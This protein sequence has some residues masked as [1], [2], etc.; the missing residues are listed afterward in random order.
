[1]TGGAPLLETRELSMRFGGV[2]AVDRANFALEPGE[3]RCLIG[4]N[5]AGKS[6]FFKCL[7][8]QLRPT[9]GSIVFDGQSIGG[10]QPHAIA[11][12]GIAIKTQVPSLFDGLSV[13]ENL[14]LA[15]R[16]HHDRPGAER[17]VDE[18][19][20]RVRLGDMAERLANHLPHGQ[21][22][23]LELGLVLASEPR[24]MLL[25][26]PTAGMSHQ[27]VARTAEIILEISRDRS[28]VVVEHD[29]QFIRMIARKVTVFH[30]GQILVEDAVER[31]M[32]D[33]RVRDIYLGKAAGETARGMRAP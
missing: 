30:Q 18:I 13:K 2:I 17:T 10:A 3:L 26:E 20:A 33:E 9:S 8:G 24:L 6:T 4:P 19:L 29:M 27:E 28:V 16:R 31:I 7:S 25:D 11:R 32:Q 22:Q 14:W 15:A 5:G 23:W 21:R 12:L 1:M